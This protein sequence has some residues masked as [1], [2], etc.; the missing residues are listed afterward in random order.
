MLFQLDEKLS[1][2]DIEGIVSIEDLP[3]EFHGQSALKVLLKLE[4]TGR[5]SAAKP[6]SLEEVLKNVNRHDLAKKV[7][8]FS[9][10]QKKRHNTAS[11]TAEER[12]R[13]LN[14]N[15]E[16]A[17]VQ[18]RLLCDQ[19]EHLHKIAQETGPK[20]VEMIISGAQEDAELLEKKLL[21][22]KTYLEDDC[23]PTCFFTPATIRPF[24]LELEQYL[25]KSRKSPGEENNAALMQ[26]ISR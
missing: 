24:E 16:V 11:A 1:A 9:K 23:S 2:H 7:K 6:Q 19:L 10:S 4:L 22:A 12:I 5:I 8:D 21:Y 26:K 25:A 13:T 18:M 17:R 3:S 20:S 14:A 15:L